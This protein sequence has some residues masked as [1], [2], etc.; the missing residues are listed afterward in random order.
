MSINPEDYKFVP[1]QNALEEVDLDRTVVFVGG[2]RY[3]EA[4]ARR[5][6][7][8]AQQ[9]VRQG[10]VPGEEPPSGKLTRPSAAS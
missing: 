7:E 8:C 3:T 5:D 4:A 1:G 2:Q 10:L 6:G 9:A